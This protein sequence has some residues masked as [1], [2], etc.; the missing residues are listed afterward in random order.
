V[1]VW[2]STTKR[3]TSDQIRIVW[4]LAPLVTRPM[5]LTCESALHNPKEIQVD[6]FAQGSLLLLP[7]FARR[8]H[9]E[10]E[11]RGLK[12]FMANGV[13]RITGTG[14]TRGPKRGPGR[15]GQNGPSEEALA[16]E[17]QSRGGRGDLGSLS[18]LSWDKRQDG[19][20]KHQCCQKPRRH[21]SG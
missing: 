5:V 6:Q 10:A 20:I 7:P 15:R 1:Y 12:I 3:V 18:L 2:Y 17:G 4:F 14:Y 16:P 21:A 19:H 13:Y 8:L 11:L 9:A